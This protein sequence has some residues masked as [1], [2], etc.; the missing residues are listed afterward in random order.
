MPSSF[1]YEIHQEEQYV[2]VHAGGSFTHWD[3]L[4]IIHQLHKDDPKKE[5]PDLWVLDRSFELS[6]YSFPPLVQGILSLIARCAIRKGCRSAI[7]AADEFQKAKVDLY[8]TEAV[9]L[10][11]EIQSFTSRSQA[12]DW[13]FN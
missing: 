7:L 1:S 8:C 9:E 10:P 13:L 3:L 5:K 6:L 2:E 4:K 11:Y 12:L